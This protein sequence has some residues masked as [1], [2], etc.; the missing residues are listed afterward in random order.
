MQPKVPPWRCDTSGRIKGGLG[1]AQVERAGPGDFQAG[2]LA[3]KR[4]VVARL[5]SAGEVRAHVSATGEE[6]NL[7]LEVKLRRKHSYFIGSADR[8]QIPRNG[9]WLA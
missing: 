6:A 7:I 9:E 3:V 4:R 8:R 5:W 2:R 1:A